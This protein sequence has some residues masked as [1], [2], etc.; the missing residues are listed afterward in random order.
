M[1]NVQTEHNIF[2]PSICF[3]KLWYYIYSLALLILE[4]F[5]LNF[6]HSVKLTKFGPFSLLSMSQ[7]FAFLYISFHSSLYYL[8]DPAN[9]PLSQD[10]LRSNS[11]IRTAVTW[12]P[13][14]VIPFLRVFQKHSEDFGITFGLPVN[15]HKAPTFL[16][17]LVSSYSVLASPCI[18]DL[19]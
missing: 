5:Y 12:S 6:S 13:A 15:T 10:A 16:S 2:F 3:L 11:S 4:M 9:W 19:V 8:R 17:I 7:F 1:L 14:H 18:E